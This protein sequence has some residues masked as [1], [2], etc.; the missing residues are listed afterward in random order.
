MQPIETPLFRITGLAVFL[1]S[2]FYT[3]RPTP[4]GYCSATKVRTTFHNA[5]RLLMAGVA[6]PRTP[7]FNV[8]NEGLHFPPGAYRTKVRTSAN[9]NFQ[10]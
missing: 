9:T 4:P 2:R 8:A 7:R 6:H 5:P 3:G 1:N 10:H